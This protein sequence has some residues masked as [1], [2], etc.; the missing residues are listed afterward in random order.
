M[1]QNE[2]KMRHFVSHCGR[3]ATITLCHC[4]HCCHRGYLCT[5]APSVSLIDR[6][7]FGAWPTQR[8][9]EL[10]ITSF[11]QLGNNWP[12]MANYSIEAEEWWRVMSTAGRNVSFDN[13]RINWDIWH[14]TLDIGQVPTTVLLHAHWD[15]LENINSKYRCSRIF[16]LS[17]SSWTLHFILLCFRCWKIITAYPTDLVYCI[18]LQL[19]WISFNTK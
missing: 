13:A 3:A 18:I 17:I 9:S 4:C 1:R 14:R 2:S 16:V 5:A 19:L 15:E 6:E 10:E 7:V 11:S 12:T 8:R